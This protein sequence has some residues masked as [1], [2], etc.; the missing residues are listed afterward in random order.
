MH[1]SGS[2][3]TTAVLLFTGFLSIAGAQQRA[4][5]LGPLVLQQPAV[6][7]AVELART[8]EL[9]TIDD[10]IRI[11]E[12][13]APPF[14]ET[15]RAELYASMFK[16]AGLKNV[17]LD[18][19]GNV[20]G[21][22]PGAGARPNLVMSAH[23]DTVFP[24][25]TN[26][27]VRRQG[28]V[29]K[30]AGIGDDCRGLADLLA[31]A[32]A[33]NKAGVSTPGTITFVGTVG[34]EGL[35]DLRGV[36]RL[37]NETLKDRIDRF[38]SIDGEGLGITH[39]A[40]G[41]IRFRVTFKGPGGHSFGS[42]GIVNPIH[43]LGRA[44]AR[45]ADFQVPGLPRT[46]FNVGRVG[47]GT[48]VNAI[49]SEAWMEVDLRSGDAVTL[50]ALEKQFRQAVQ[51]AVAQENARWNSQSL[52]VAIDTV[53]MR[54]AGRVSSTSP[55]V[56]AAVSVSKALNLPIS[57]AEGS[58]DSNLPLSLGIPALTIDTGGRGSGAHT[59][60]ET[61]DATEAWKG[62]QRAVLL[63]VVLAQP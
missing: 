60:Q 38:V 2:L 31:V 22:R 1:Q 49:A 45:I 57:F 9:R 62:T 7:A 52:T 61:F 36:K 5:E 26:V 32:R 50:R 24:R 53:G 27:S 15:K 43:A 28:Y 34:E 33:L 14:Q 58:T 10:Q 4:A 37:F 13:E 42:F 3:L 46:T 59:E 44:M 11:C 25:G 12:V 18:A 48:S 56:Q 63:A 30:G 23:L 19:E 21:E 17:R 16:E 20:I 35:G 39:I 40:I 29:L 55:I 54:P 8:D 6:R 47:G 51:E 41:S